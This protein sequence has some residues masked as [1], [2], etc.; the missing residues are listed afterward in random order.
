VE[1]YQLN[2]EGDNFCLESLINHDLI[3]CTINLSCALL[4]AN[5][6]HQD[7]Q[8]LLWMRN[9]LSSLGGLPDQAYM[10]AMT[11]MHPRAK[12]G[13]EVLSKYS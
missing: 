3:V 2:W 12:Q 8:S 4:T 7:H 1:T 10:Q 9:N 6:G 13:L 5:S 11:A